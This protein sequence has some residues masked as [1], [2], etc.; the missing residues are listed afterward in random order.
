MNLL[1]NVKLI[2]SFYYPYIPVLFQNN[3]GIID[4]DVLEPL[5]TMKHFTFV[6]DFFH[7]QNYTCK[8]YEHV[9]I[10]RTEDEKLET[11]QWML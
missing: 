2:L 7:T 6:F 11:L 1:Q 9:S 4:F 10:I 5:A 3:N 8:K